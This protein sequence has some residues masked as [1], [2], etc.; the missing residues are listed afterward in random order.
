MQNL[1]AVFTEN[2]LK[3]ISNFNIQQYIPADQYQKCGKNMKAFLSKLPKSELH[4]HIEGTFEP[5]LAFKI[6][7]RNNI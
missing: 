6:A 3:G 5:D 1:K 7:K 4:L 2:D